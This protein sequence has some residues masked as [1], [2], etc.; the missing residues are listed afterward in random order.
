MMHGLSRSIGHRI[1]LSRFSLPKPNYKFLAIA[2][3][4]ITAGQNWGLA[5]ATT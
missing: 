4:Y 3:D 1:I 2:E 5:I